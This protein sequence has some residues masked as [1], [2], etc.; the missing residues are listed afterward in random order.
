M[1]V[2]P[3]NVPV[4]PNVPLVHFSVAVFKAE[5]GL[6]VTKVFP[7]TVVAGNAPT[8]TV[9]FGLN[10]I[11][12]GLLPLEDTPPGPVTVRFSVPR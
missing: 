12:T 5:A 9:P 4:A 6:F 2:G 1:T 3:L 10:T 11:T 8:C 7:W